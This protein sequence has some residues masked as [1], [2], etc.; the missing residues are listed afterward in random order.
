LGA[1]CITTMGK[2]GTLVSKCG[3]TPTTCGYLYC[4]SK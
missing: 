1:S 3:S 2:P 4:I